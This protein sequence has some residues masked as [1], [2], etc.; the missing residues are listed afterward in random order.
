MALDIII[1]LV[2][3]AIIFQKLW[4]LLGTKPQ[5]TTTPI[6]QESAAKIFDILIKESQKKNAENAT[7]DGGNL[8]ARPA[9]MTETEK[10]LQQISGFNSDNFLEGAKRAFEMIVTAFSKED[11][12]T[13]QL[14]IDKDLF[15]RFDD[16]IK[17]RKAEGI[18]SETDFVG[19]NSA[20]I[21]NAV[22]KND[23]ARITVR[24]VSEQA[25]VLRDAEGNV[26]EGDENFIQS[27]TDVWTFERN[28]N[29]TSPNWLL[30]STK[31]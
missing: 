9:N 27:I 26:I 31:K 30:V 23:T 12:E 15:K 13:L 28:L 29:S 3:V 25:N 19:F 14:L 17:Q 16:I 4:G 5:N 20:E 22:I 1:L 18:T 24:F 6:S 21:T 10:V 2:V 8:E 7:V 11:T